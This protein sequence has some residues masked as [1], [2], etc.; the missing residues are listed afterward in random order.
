MIFAG[1]THEPAERLARG[2]IDIA[3]PGLAHVFFSDSGSTAVEVA[4]KMALGYWRNIGEPRHRI[5]ALEHGYHGDTIGG[6]SVGARGVFNA[7]YEPLLFDVARIP[8]PA[9]G[10]EQETHRRARGRLR[11]TSPSPRSS[12]SR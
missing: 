4:L 5:V 3:P 10:R 7:P 9:P 8:F 11:A 12:S 2:L 1:F 6:M